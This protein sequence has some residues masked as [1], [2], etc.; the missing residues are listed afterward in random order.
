MPGDT[1]VRVRAAG[2][3]AVEQLSY[4]RGRTVLAVLGVA[5]AVLL[6]VALGSVG[7]GTLTTGDQAVDW[8]QHD[9]WVTGDGVDLDPTS[10]G[11]VANP[12]T[13][14]HELSDELES[15]DGV[16]HAR[17]VAFQSVYVSPDGEDFD[18]VVGVGV[19]GDAARLRIASRFNRRDIHYDDGTYSGP[20]TNR[21]VVG[22][23]LARQYDLEEG[24]TLHVGGTIASA[25]A[26]EFTIVG[27][28]GDFS[29]FLGT[30]T[31]GLHLS[32]LQEVSGTTGTDPAALVAVTLESGADRDA[33]EHDIEQRYPWLSVRTDDEQV[34][35][36]IGTHAPLVASGITLVG[37]AVCSAVA[38]VTIVLRLMVYQ[39]RRQLAALRASG[40]STRTLVAVVTLQGT[41]IGLAGSVL[42][43]GAAV[44]AVVVLDHGI[45]R[46]TG[47][48]GLVQAPPWLLAGGVAFALVVGILGAASAGWHVVRLDPLDQLGR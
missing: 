27:I 15:R 5:L 29:N 37:L 32:E 36:T 21:V 26:H 7:Y 17:S 35:A 25:R 28:T 33:V 43:G 44:P 19:G 46:M 1:A 3:V 30:P 22:P 4:H 48:S 13:G 40:I 38:V 10:V 23:S 8:F 24:D 45:E 6:V 34:R 42:G 39:Q 31:V 41:G 12:I 18:T 14:A 20:M 9:L 11:G 47:V 16:A 2:R